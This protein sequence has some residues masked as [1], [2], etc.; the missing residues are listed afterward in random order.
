MI[1]DAGGG[2]AY[3]ALDY[4]DQASS[5]FNNIATGLEE[6][7]HREEKGAM[8]AANLTPTAEDII[9]YYELGHLQERVLCSVI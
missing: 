3:E 7:M 4:F 6:K 1:G 8:D 5:V 9:Q 2:P